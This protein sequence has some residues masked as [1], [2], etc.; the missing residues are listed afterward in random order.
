MS[1]SSE[2]INETVIKEMSDE[3][4]VDVCEM[5]IDVFVEELQDM[6]KR[7]EQALLNEDRMEIIAVAH[8]LKNSA[9]QYGATRLAELACAIHDFPKSDNNLLLAD[10]KDMLITSQKTKNLYQTLNLS[11]N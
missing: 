8:I 3:L 11:F 6:M 7:Q 5:L 4:G 10:T 1:L 9:A 2:L